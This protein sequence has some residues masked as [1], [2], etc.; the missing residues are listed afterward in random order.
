MPQTYP[1]F[2]PRK[3]GNL[4]VNSK[5]EIRAHGFELLRGG[6]VFF[7]IKIKNEADHDAQC[8]HRKVVCTML[9]SGR[10][11]ILIISVVRKANASLLALP[12]WPVHS[13]A[14]CRFP[15]RC[16]THSAFGIAGLAWW[17]CKFCLLTLK[18]VSSY[19]LRGV[20]F[21]V[22]VLDHRR[23]L[24]YFFSKAHY[25]RVPLPQL[26]AH[27]AL[28]VPCLSLAARLALEKD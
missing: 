15:H 8:E 11:F 19:R 12:P 25:V 26:L 18:L 28:C 13:R 23:H 3:F 22:L 10:G 17:C 4:E 20:E 9:K 1:F 21:R 27:H 5:V 6:A 2:R 24:L 7:K 14:G 16:H